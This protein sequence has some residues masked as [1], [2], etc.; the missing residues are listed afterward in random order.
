MPHDDH[1]HH[2]HHHH[3][4]MHHHS[5]GDTQ[6][7]GGCLV[8]LFVL[9]LVIW[10][11]RLTVGLSLLLL[12]AALIPLWVKLPDWPKAVKWTL[13][14]MLLAIWLA[15]MPFAVQLLE[16]NTSP[17]KDAPEPTAVTVQTEIP[18]E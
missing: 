2:E 5:H 10:L 1:C 18:A 6:G 13:T 4:S 14:V 12:P 15:V 8:C 11:V 3:T 16:S 17:D 9:G 7:L